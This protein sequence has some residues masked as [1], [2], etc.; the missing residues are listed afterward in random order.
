AWHVATAALGPDEQVAA[1]LEQAATEAIRRS[2]YAAAARALERAATL[3][4]E[5]DARLRRLTEAAEAAWGA[6][7]TA[8]ALAPLQGALERCGEPRLRAR[9]L[10]LRYQIERLSGSVL[11]ALDNLVA[12]AELVAELDPK[13]AVVILVDASEAAIYGADVQ[14]SLALAERARELA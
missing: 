8:H 2:G 7:R 3:S 14:A 10:H 6:G 12:A 9:V 13:Q 5:D 11:E 1:A 4:P